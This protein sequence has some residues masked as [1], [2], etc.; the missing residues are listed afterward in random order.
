MPGLF[1]YAPG[2]SRTMPLVRHGN[3]AMIP[4]DKIQVDSGFAYV[5]LVEMRS[6]GGMSGS[7]VFV[8][9]T[10]EV[11][12][13]KDQKFFGLLPQVSLLGLVHGHWDISPSDIDKCKPRPQR[14][15]VNIG[16][17]VVVPAEKILEVLNHPELVAMR[18]SWDEKYQ[19]DV[20]P[21][22]D[23]C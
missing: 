4:D 10:V 20:S 15:G 23:E 18:A 1:V 13:S 5:Y 6:I 12:F 21:K 14:G 7:P 3:I 16:V 2:T 19:A 11:E 8:R 9:P 17:G 22:P